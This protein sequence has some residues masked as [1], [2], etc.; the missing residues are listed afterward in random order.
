MITHGILALN[1]RKRK[2]QKA[3]L[4]ACFFDI[5]NTIIADESFSL[6]LRVTFLNYRSIVLLWLALAKDDGILTGED[7]KW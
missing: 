7:L 1:F 3:G 2:K 4:A 5:G 6:N